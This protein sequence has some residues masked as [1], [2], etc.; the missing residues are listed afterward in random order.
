MDLRSHADGIPRLLQVT[1]TPDELDYLRIGMIGNMAT[2][3]IRH[4]FIH[5]EE[6]GELFDRL[7]DP[8]EVHNSIN[9]KFAPLFGLAL[10]EKCDEFHRPDCAVHNSQC[11]GLVGVKS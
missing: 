6:L 2:Q 11:D 10:C 9:R 4:I 3:S 7:P 5:H 8:T 1:L